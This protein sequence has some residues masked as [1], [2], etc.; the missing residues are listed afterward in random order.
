MIRHIVMFKMKQE[1]SPAEKVAAL[2]LLYKELVVLGTKIPEILEWQI[3]INIHVDNASA[4]DILLNSTFNS[5]EDL[6][7]YQAHPDHQ[8]FITFNKDFSESKA[9]LDYSI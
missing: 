9:V 2:H 7:V 6:A 8:A 1:F 5:M 4:Y 3:G